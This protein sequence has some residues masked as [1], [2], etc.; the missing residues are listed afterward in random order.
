MEEN[1]SRTE[2]WRRSNRE[3][4]RDPRS[5]LHGYDTL[6]KSTR[7]ENKLQRKRIKPFREPSYVNLV[8][9][10]LLLFMQGSTR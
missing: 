6:L 4:A 9:H 7:T 8:W 3:A 1:D 2:S 5:Y 10:S